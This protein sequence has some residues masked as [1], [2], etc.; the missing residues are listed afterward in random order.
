V[1]GVEW[2]FDC[3]ER[4]SSC[5]KLSSLVLR[6]IAS[7]TMSEVGDKKEQFRVVNDLC[8]SVQKS[9]RLNAY[10]IMC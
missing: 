2:D 6:Y 5:L 4:G 8:V 10:K 9:Y 3:R 7:S 1:P